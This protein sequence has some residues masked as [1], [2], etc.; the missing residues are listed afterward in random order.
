M[1]TVLLVGGP[2]HGALKALDSLQAHV[3]TYVETPASLAAPDRPEGGLAFR[4]VT[5]TC[6]TLALS[7]RHRLEVGIAP[8]LTDSEA[9]ALAVQAILTDTHARRTVQVL[10]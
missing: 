6:R 10:P 8:G 5:Y 9:Q 3:Q 1:R 4:P 7:H 2:A